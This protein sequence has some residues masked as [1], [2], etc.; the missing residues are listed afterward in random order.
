M[1]IFDHSLCNSF[2]TK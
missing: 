2:S 1:D